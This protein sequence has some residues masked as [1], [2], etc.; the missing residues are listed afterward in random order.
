MHLLFYRR[1]ATLITTVYPTFPSIIMSRNIVSINRVDFS[2][3]HEHCS[4]TNHN[5]MLRLFF[6]MKN[7][8]LKAT[9]V[10][11]TQKTNKQTNKEKKTERYIM[12]FICHNWKLF[13]NFKLH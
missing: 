4:F 12:I 6:I 11:C 1:L 5:I 3:R 10:I 13:S 8:H 9:F 7:V 2:A